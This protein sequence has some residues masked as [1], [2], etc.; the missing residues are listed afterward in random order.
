MPGG[1]NG[2]DLAEL[3]A[4]SN[5][6]IA[7]VVVSGGNT[8]DLISAHALFYTKPY[9]LRELLNIVCMRLAHARMSRYCRLPERE[10]LQSRTSAY[11]NSAN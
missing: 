2:F 3:V 7:I 1:L 4:R 9:D 11:Q 10:G 8:P 6:Q 5:D